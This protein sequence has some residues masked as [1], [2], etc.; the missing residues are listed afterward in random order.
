MKILHP[1]PTVAGS[2]TDS[3]FALYLRKRGPSIVILLLIVLS[4]NLIALWNGFAGIEDKQLVL[5]NELIRNL[6]FSGLFKLFTSATQGGYHPLVDISI[7]LD[8]RIGGF[9]PLSYHAQNLF[10]HLINVWLVY[11][12]FRRLG[13]NRTK[14]WMVALFFGIHPLHAESIAWVNGRKDVLYAA[15]FLFSILFYYRYTVSGNKYFYRLSLVGFVWA[16]LCKPMAMSL[17]LLLPLIDY[18]ENRKINWRVTISEKFPFFFIGIVLVWFTFLAQLNEGRI[19]TLHN[20]QEFLFVCRALVFYI[21]RTVMPIQLSTFYPFPE[22]PELRDYLAPVVLIGLLITFFKILPFSRVTLSGWLFFFV[23]ILPVLQLFPAGQALM[24]DRNHYIAGLGLLYLIVEFSWIAWYRY[25]ILRNS[26]P[27]AIV[28]TVI[29]FSAIQINRIRVWRNDESF[30]GDI[31]SYNPDIYA[32]NFN[33]AQSRYNR[34]ESD[35]ALPLYLKLTELYPDSIQ[36]YTGAGKTFLQAGKYYAA[37]NMYRKAIGLSSEPEIYYPE[38]A[39]AS[40]YQQKWDTAL[41]YFRASI[42]EYPQNARYRIQLSEAYKNTGQDSLATHSLYQALNIDSTNG[43]AYYQMAL[44]LAKQG[45]LSESRGWMKVAASKG[46]AEAQVAI[47]QDKTV[48]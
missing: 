10:W 35:Q 48:W 34:Q 11:R 42:K 1:S 7:A 12:I 19:G 4:V 9:N 5:E 18:L 37:E 14:G 6:D 40:L 31:L 27:I 47:D 24:A 41:Y 2:V 32:A 29:I 15:G 13:N 45:K 33:L 8:F 21:S 46:I 22:S 39:Q 25:Q 17:P 28:L 16:C 30:Y 26:L 20:W 23:C 3:S 43:Q 38:L 44:L 36:A